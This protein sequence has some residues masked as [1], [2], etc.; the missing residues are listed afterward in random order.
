[1]PKWKKVEARDGQIFKIDISDEACLLCSHGYFKH[2]DGFFD[3]VGTEGV[4]LGVAPAVE[5]HA[6]PKVLV[7]WYILKTTK[8]KVVC[9]SASEKYT[10]LR[11]EGFRKKR[12]KKK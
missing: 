8:R 9:W 7:L 10:D 2:G 5:K 11:K 4:I 6:A 12:K 3:P 1:M